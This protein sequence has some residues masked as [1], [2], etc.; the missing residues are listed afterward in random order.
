[1]TKRLISIILVL[2]MIFS[3]TACTAD[4][5]EA[6]SK[7]N[8][9]SPAPNEGN[10]ELTIL[11]N[12]VDYPTIKT[13]VFSNYIDKFEKDFGVK[14]N[15]EKI[16][17]DAS[18]WITPEEQDFYIKKLFPKLSVKEGPEL[19]F[20]EYMSMGALIKQQ[21]FVDLQ[22][23]LVNLNKVYD[24]LLE[25]KVYYA[26]VGMRY[27]A[28]SLKQDALESVGIKAPDLDWSSKEYYDIREK[29]ITY[30]VVYFN[31]YEYYKVFNSF[32]NL[33]SLYNEEA[34]HVIINT[35]E[36]EQKL[37]NAR[38]YIFN[39]KYVINSNYKY[40]NYYNMIF[41]N[42]SK[43]SEEDMQLYNRNNNNGHIDG[44]NIAN[45]FRAEELSSKNKKDGTVMYPQFS[46]REVIIESCGFVVNKNGR[47][48]ELAYEF[49][50]GLLNDDIQM[51]MFNEGG[52]YFPTNKEIEADILKNESEKNLDQKAIEL[53]AYALQQ[54][55]E[56]KCKLWNTLDQS[57]SSLNFMM[58][59]DFSKFIL[60]DNPYSDV[61][62]S[63]ELQKL[64]N[65]YN[66]WLSE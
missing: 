23:K 28:Y 34:K 57:F 47:N 42:A 9:V 43:E 63:A 3:M 5:R 11:V 65:K 7:G 6:A 16:T 12:A 66:I 55:K 44:G 45:L 18:G 36:V 8:I 27:Y 64:E 49:I 32:I 52:Y 39:G 48:L 29:W 31:S 13:G 60:A 58:Y 26:P 37:R 51:S 56:G 54:L 22:G 15:F 40:R 17:T 46:D 25:E 50:N 61:E 62:L 10:A 19:I 41:E 59:K 2:L 21:A 38:D 4:K 1:M 20:A 35:P 30:N 24:K 14:I 53:K 33:K